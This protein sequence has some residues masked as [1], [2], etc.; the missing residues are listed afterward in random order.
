MATSKLLHKTA[1][2]TGRMQLLHNIH[3]QR[4]AQVY[5]KVRRRK[6]A[7][8]HT[9]QLELPQLAGIWYKSK[10]ADMV[11]RMQ[12]TAT[13]GIHRQTA[14]LQRRV[15]GSETYTGNTLCQLTVRMK[16][17]VGG[18]SSKHLVM[19]TAHS[20]AHTK[21]VLTGTAGRQAR[22]GRHTRACATTQSTSTDHH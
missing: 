15:R 11:V 5:S 16:L 18:K 3:D 22:K 21:G 8:R 6:Q 2:G 9:Q 13:T 20:K 12:A 7:C 4:L 19:L 1:H 14:T 10:V 17:Q